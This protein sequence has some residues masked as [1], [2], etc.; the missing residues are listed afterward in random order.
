[1]PVCVSSP[2]RVSVGATTRMAASEYELVNLGRVSSAALM[3]SGVAG[4]VMPE[5]VASAL[6]LAPASSRGIA[7]VRAGL[8]GTDAALG[9]WALVSRRHAAGVAVGASWL[10]VATARLV[11]LAI[12]RPQTDAAF[13]AY[14]VAEVGFGT[15][16]LAAARDRLKAKA[17]A[18]GRP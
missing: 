1:V 5:R 6:Q 8:G 10:G 16:A 14:L 12:D 13:W 11:S 2:S 4:V 15:I 7:E 3:L 18:E 17:A 9:A